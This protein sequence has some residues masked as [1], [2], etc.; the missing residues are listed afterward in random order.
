M[1]SSFTCFCAFAVLLLSTV[2]CDAPDLRGTA[3]PASVD[4]APGQRVAIRL[5][6]PERAGAYG[7]EWEVR[8]AG[9][10]DIRYVVGGSNGTKRAP[11]MPQ[12][13]GCGPESTGGCGRSAVFIPVREG[14][15]EIRVT[16][17]IRP[18]TFEAS[19]HTHVVTT[20]PVSVRSQAGQPPSPEHVLL[21][22]RLGRWFYRTGGREDSVPGD[23]ARACLSPGGRWIA[24]ATTVSPGS[25]VRVTERSSGA[26][27]CAFT[28]EGDV[29][30][31][32][33][34]SS[35]ATLAVVAGQALWLINPVD[36][37][38][39]RRGWLPG[40]SRIYSVHWAGLSSRLDYHTITSI[41]HA[42]EGHLAE[43]QEQAVDSYLGPGE[44]LTSADVIVP[45]PR[46]EASF[47]F[48]RPVPTGQKPDTRHALFLHSEGRT[49]EIGEP[50][51]SYLEVV[52]APDGPWIYARKVDSRSAGG[53]RLV[54]ITL[55]DGPWT[56][57]VEGAELVSIG[58]PCAIP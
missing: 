20:I 11:E 26:E 47:A 45:L 33:W 32:A 14:N 43:A 29:G 56:D 9:L 12:D 55:P 44:P 46:E 37:G 40:D 51:G 4:A 19:P 34:S 57:V 7:I 1:S 42:F 17:L 35:G 8:P 52:P 36:P 10:G 50:G 58:A 28:V 39:A 6:I 23:F 41:W 3:V 16:A 27:R 21:Y 54:R 48:T 49:R 31:F 5:A 22:R 18:G 13:P 2:G 38:S 53:T 15:G 24:T 25:R 30:R